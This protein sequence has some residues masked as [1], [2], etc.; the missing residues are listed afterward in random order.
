LIN[1]DTTGFNPNFAPESTAAK[2][3]M[4]E[5]SRSNDEVDVEEAIALGGAGIGETVLSTSHLT[6]SLRDRFNTRLQ[7]SRMATVLAA[8]GWHKVDHRTK[9]RGETVRVYVKNL[10]VVTM[11]T[12][13]ANAFI[14]SELDATLLDDFEAVDL[15][16]DDE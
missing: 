3:V 9:W 7:T 15:V 14:R 12:S 4:I 10:E 13:A 6:H 5:N 2:K 1:V 8:L 16:D 11:G